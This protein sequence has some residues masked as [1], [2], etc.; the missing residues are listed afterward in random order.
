[1]EYFHLM[2]NISHKEA[3]AAY[4][5]ESDAP[6]KVSGQLTQKEILKTVMATGHT[7]VVRAVIRWVEDRLSDKTRDLSTTELD[8][9]AGIIEIEPKAFKHLL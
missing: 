7:H 8:V 3:L 1:M 4:F 5:R 2:K 9:I 6:K